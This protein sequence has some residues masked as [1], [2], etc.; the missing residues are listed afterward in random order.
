MIDKLRD[1]KWN[2]VAAIA[3]CFIIALTVLSITV[4]HVS[5]TTSK[6][7]R[8]IEIP[9]QWAKDYVE[10]ETAYAELE[11]QRNIVW[12]NFEAT[13]DQIV[14]L[15]TNSGGTSFTTQS[16]VPNLSHQD[17]N[18]EMIAL[19]QEDEAWTFITNGKI[20]SYPTNSYSYYAPLLRDLLNENT[21]TITVDVWYWANPG[22]DTDFSKVTKQKTF[23]VNS[24]LASTFEHIFADIYAHE[25][26]PVFNLA[27]TG[28]GT[29]VLRSKVSGSGLSAHAIG[30]C[31]DINPSTGSFKVDGKWYGNGYGQNVMTESMWKQL[32]E[33]HNK[34]HV[35]YDG[36]PIVEVFKAYGFYWGGDWTGTKDPMHIAFL[37]DGTNGRFRGIQN[38]LERKK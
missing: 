7:N 11:E 5:G 10:D 35:L 36:C 12:E 16:E 26:Q 29:W 31:I 37:G 1:V 8:N 14:H 2:E 27:D 20:N 3:C 15:G 28:M 22:D 30:V 19:M 13:P 4:V 23:A 21:E 18:D 24:K 25:S 32:P 9:A 34:Y 6:T 38:Y 17:A 33:S